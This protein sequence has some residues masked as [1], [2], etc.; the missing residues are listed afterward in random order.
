MPLRGERHLKLLC[1]L[2]KPLRWWAFWVAHHHRHSSITAQADLSIEWNF[3]QKRH[4]LPFGLGPS[5]PVPKNLHTVPRWGHEIAH[6][7]NDAQNRDI[8]LFKHRYSLAHDTKRGLLRRGHNDSPIQ[9]HGLT[10]RKL[11]IACP[12]RK[13]DQ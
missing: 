10:E 3:P 6:V 13:I 4:A 11:R 8:H 7:L 9:R 1:D 5:T 12:R 2:D